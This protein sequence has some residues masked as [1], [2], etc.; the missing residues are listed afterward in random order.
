[1]ENSRKKYQFQSY[2]YL[3]PAFIVFAIFIAYTIFFVFRISFYQ[4]DG[5]SPNMQFVGFKNYEAIWKSGQLQVALRNFVLFFVLSVSMQLLLG[6][7]LAVSLRV[8]T[9]IRTIIKSIIFIPVVLTPIVIGYVFSNML[10]SN[11]GFVN[12]LLHNL[13]LDFLAQN[14]LSDPKF[15]LASI[16]VISIW[17]STGFSMIMYIAGI[18]SIPN[19][20]FEAAKI[21]GAGPIKTFFRVTF[22]MLKSTHATMLILSAIGALKVFDI[23]WVL[24]GG[25][26]GNTTATFS[27]LIMKESFDSFR[28]GTSSA[29]SVILILLALLITA[30]QVALYNRKDYTR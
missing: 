28:Q 1:M 25:G 8:Q 11:L 27:T 26:P 29:L 10:E 24:T 14:W 5:F 20:V 2:L 3:L 17:Q 22:P 12:T 7:V 13:N 21:D 6:M 9:V 19:E 15:A 30:F 4:W 16:I 18:V 23:V